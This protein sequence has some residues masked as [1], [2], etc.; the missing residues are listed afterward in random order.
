MRIPALITATAIL[1]LCILLP[2]CIN[3]STAMSWRSVTYQLTPE[4]AAELQLTSTPGAATVN[5]E[6]TTSTSDAFKT[7]GAAE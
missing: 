4:A 1:A 7:D 2:G 6:K 3:S 5:A